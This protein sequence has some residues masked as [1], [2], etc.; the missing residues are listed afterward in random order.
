MSISATI[1]YLVDDDSDF[2]KGLEPVLRASGLELRSFGTGEAFLNAFPKLPP[3]CLFVDLAMPDMS[4][5]DL[6]RRLR[7]MGCRWPI[8]VLTGHGS[9]VSA[10]DAMRSGAFAFLEKPVRELELI[11]TA[12]KAQA[13]LSG[14]TGVLYDEEIAQRIQR[15]SRREREVLDRLVQGM[16]NKQIA[17]QLGIGES[18]VKSARRAIMQRMRVETRAELILMAL[19]GGLTIKGRF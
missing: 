8:V 11:A 18:T 1:V 7:A 12:R 13:L 19:R 3:G 15:L 5:L 10:T 14:S 4:G 16:V 17:A 9:A 6:L 2:R